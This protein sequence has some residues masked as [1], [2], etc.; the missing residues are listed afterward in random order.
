M[1]YPQDQS[2]D[3]TPLGTED[4][5]ARGR[6]AFVAGRYADAADLLGAYCAGHPDDAAAACD[7]GSALIAGGRAANAAVALRAALRAEPGLVPARINLG[8]A[9]LKLDRPH[10]ALT[11]L[12]EASAL[13]PDDPVA[14]FNQG[15][16]LRCAGRHA[17]AME[18][19][20]R[21]EGLRPAHPET[22]LEQG[23]VLRDAGRA[24]EAVGAYRRALALRPGWPDAARELA[25]LL[26]AGRRFE[27]AAE[28]FRLALAAAPDDA[29]LWNELGSALHGAGRHAEALDGFRRS[30]LAQPGL[31]AASCNMALALASLGRWDEAVAAGRKAVA[32]DMAGAVAHMNL[33]YILLALGRYREGWEEYEYRFA[34]G[35]RGWFR[36]EAGG[37]P[38]LGEALAGRSILVLG[39]QGY[40]D[41]IQFARYL[42]LLADMGA[43]VTF[44]APVRLHRLLRTLPGHITAVDAVPAGTRFDLQWPLMSLPLRWEQQGAGIP[45]G[46]P[47][48]NAEPER[49]AR[50]RER[51]GADGFRIGIAWQGN[52]QGAVDV[53]RSF[54]LERMRP[55]AAIPGVRLISL[56]LGEAS[57]QVADLLPGMA[58]EVLD[59]L[60]T[61]GEDAFLDTAAAM[62]VVDLVVT[63]DTAVA[64]LAGALGRPVWIAL[65]STPEWRWQHVREDSPWYATARLFRQVR[66]GD[67]DEVFCRIAAALAAIVPRTPADRD[68]AR[69]TLPT[70]RIPVSFG[71]LFDRVSILEIKAE[72]FTGDALANVHR[73]LQGLLAAVAVLGPTPPGL[74]ELRDRLRATNERLWLL[75]DEIRA[76][77]A[78]GQFDD[79]FVTAAR[80]IYF[81]N[82]ERGRIKRKINEASG[83][84]LIEE[85]HYQAY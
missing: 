62:E 55:L 6:A 76:F 5:A 57:G 10:E 68:A 64:H 78:V 13:A 79:A 30:L 11:Q 47:Y 42:P 60:D 50:W 53:G 9:L 75:E 61:G 26:Q 67:W 73:D 41:H 74:A 51:I 69:P 80:A 83:S 77:E 35:K 7:L 1:S 43:T 4:G 15:V 27:E 72:R 71:D 59:G 49:V 34:A 16:A 66:A 8:V 28:M 24:D 21:A 25:R 22:A 82:D 52:K 38:W 32:S 37:E 84:P 18:C 3:G 63:S 29:G 56:Q 40:G 31:S 48:L 54:T 20:R 45:P 65:S 85:K 36:P 70:P 17:D 14:R 81:V 23:H 39:E 46:A 2:A 44:M 58:V 33:G 19:L 12:E